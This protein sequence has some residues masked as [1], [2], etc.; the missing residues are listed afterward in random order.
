MGGV[1]FNGV[2]LVGEGEREIV[3]RGISIFLNRNRVSSKMYG[4]LY[5]Y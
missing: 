2:K 3:F 5:T 1:G 4:I